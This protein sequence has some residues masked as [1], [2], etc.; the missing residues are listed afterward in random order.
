MCARSVLLNHKQIVATRHTICD[1]AR[2][3]L[4]EVAEEVVEEV[5][6]WE[7]SRSC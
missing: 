6:G 2:Q 3:M 1:C 7:K 4:E 5:G